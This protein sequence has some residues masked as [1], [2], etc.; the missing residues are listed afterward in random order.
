MRGAVSMLTHWDTQVGDVR[1]ENPISFNI[2]QEDQPSEY[3]R[4]VKPHKPHR[5]HIQVF[6]MV[7]RGVS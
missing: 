4:R 6:S 1:D 5:M 2:A 7:R 3:H